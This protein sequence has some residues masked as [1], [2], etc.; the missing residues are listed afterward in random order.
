[1]GFEADR[2]LEQSINRLRSCHPTLI[3]VGV[4]IF[5]DVI[6][7][8]QIIDHDSRRL[9]EPALAQIRSPMNGV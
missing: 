5:L 9:L 6:E 2:L 8:I 7:V 1:M 3:K 4:M